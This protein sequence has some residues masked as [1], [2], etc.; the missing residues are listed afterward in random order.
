MLH[1]ELGCSF[2]VTSLFFLQHLG[3]N[4][5]FLCLSGYKTMVI[6][7]CYHFMRASLVA[8]MVKNSPSMQET[9]V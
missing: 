8:Q 9:Q 5:Q 6:Q 2:W 3:Q 1:R 7:K 4:N